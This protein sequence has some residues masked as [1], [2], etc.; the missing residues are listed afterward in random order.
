MAD[1]IL[2]LVPHKTLHGTVSILQRRPLIVAFV[3]LQKAYDTVQHD[4]LWA[5]LE[6]IGVS[7]RILRSLRSISC[8]ARSRR[9]SGQDSCQSVTSL[10]C[11]T[12]SI[13]LAPPSALCMPAL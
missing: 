2:V 9:A 11:A 4:L 6:A 7:P 12:S 10:P 8:A 5:P 13:Q 1:S 3:D